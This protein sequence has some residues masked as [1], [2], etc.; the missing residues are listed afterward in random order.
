MQAAPNTLTP[1]PATRKPSATPDEIAPQSLRKSTSDAT[2]EL[3][4]E[5][6]KVAAIT[7]I[8]HQEE[9]PLLRFAYSFV[10]RRAV[11][12]DLVQEVFLQ[13]H[14]HWENIDHTRAW[15]FRC[16]RNRALNHIRDHQRE[17]LSDKIIE[18]ENAS[19]QSLSD[20]ECERMERAG[21]LR[22]A[23]AELD[24]SDRQLVE[25]KYF[26]DLKYAQI[27]ERTG[28]S[29]SNVGYRLHHALKSLRQ[30]L[31]AQF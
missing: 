30:S 5:P 31:A 7:A 11:A 29:V 9:S 14:E 26:E 13:L 17:I 1:L 2:G 8:F 16:V 21:L 18:L 28:L 27:A 22:L 25:L 3:H 6:H 20:S 23:I 24:E 15:L 10:K 19:D 4:S 12:E